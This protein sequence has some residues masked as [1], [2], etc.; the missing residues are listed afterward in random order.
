MILNPYVVERGVISV[1]GVDRVVSAVSALS[2][3]LQHHTPGG[4]GNHHAPH[5][6]DG[7]RFLPVFG[8]AVT[9]HKLM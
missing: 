9:P 3:S 6:I 2:D 8:R 5:A 1:V 4:Q 7:Y